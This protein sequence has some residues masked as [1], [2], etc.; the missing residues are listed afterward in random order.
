MKKIITL[1]LSLLFAAGLS[2]LAVAGSLDSP[3]APSAGSG[4]YTLQNLYDYLTNGTALT[5]QTGFQE[6]TS[7]P[8]STMKTTREIGDA[9]KALHDQCDV[10]AA[11]VALGKRFFCTQPGS[12]GVRTGIGQMVP[13]PT[14]TITPTP[15]Y[16]YYASCKA[17]KTATPSA[18]DGTYTIDPDGQGG[19]A[20]FD[21]YCDMTN[22]GGGWT[23]IMKG[24]K[25]NTF[26]Y[27]ANYWTTS[28]TLNPTDLSLTV[29]SAKYPSFNTMPFTAI[30]GCVDHATTNCLMHTFGSS[31]SSAVALFTG[32]YLNEGVTMSEFNTAFGRTSGCSAEASGFNITK[33]QVPCDAQDEGGMRWG[34]IPHRWDSG[35]CGSGCTDICAVQG[36]GSTS[37]AADGTGTFGY[38]D[39]CVGCS[40]NANTKNDFYLWTR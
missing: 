8:G 19:N 13:T 9:I 5:V 31:K 7:G 17:I 22:N 12:W 1:A 28:N 18:A 23:L 4:M 15:T 30:R 35:S 29:G 3:G 11:D 10:T 16:A 40:P 33:T 34:L 32:G 38:F 21:A 14:P 20:P 39:Y 27:E 25:N 24:T 2:G 6:P 36:F 26:N 37:Q